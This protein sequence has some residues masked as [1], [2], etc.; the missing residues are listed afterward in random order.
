M[1]ASGEASLTFQSGKHSVPALQTIAGEGLT[2]L[3]FLTGLARTCRA[4]R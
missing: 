2:A 3:E 1:H 4:G